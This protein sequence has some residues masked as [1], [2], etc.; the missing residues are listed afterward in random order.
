MMPD[1]PSY[2]TLKIIQNC[3]TVHCIGKSF[4]CEG[5]DYFEE[6]EDCS[7]SFHDV[8]SCKISLKQKEM[9][10]IV[11]RGIIEDT[12]QNCSGVLKKKNLKTI[13]L[14]KMYLYLINCQGTSL[15]FTVF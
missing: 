11:E 2:T 12:L 4:S 10:C 7:P 9:Y 14:L 6:R 15:S 5:Q 13:P 3:E 1:I 8:D